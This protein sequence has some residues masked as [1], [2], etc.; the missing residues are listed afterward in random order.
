[1]KVQG[2]ASRLLLDLGDSLP[3]R[4]LKLGKQEPVALDWLC[5]QL[6][7]YPVRL[8]LCFGCTT[9]AI[10]ELFH[11]QILIRE[12]KISVSCSSL[13]F[14]DPAD[15]ACL[16]ILLLSTFRRRFAYR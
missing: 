3:S 16:A 12:E 8:L 13:R 2:G 7:I 9:C 4:C 15:A 5:F 1:M 10:L 11:V 14:R 6:L